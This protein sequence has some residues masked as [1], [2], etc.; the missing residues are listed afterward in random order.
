MF[1][2]RVGMACVSVGSDHALVTLPRAS[3]FVPS[4]SVNIQYRLCLFVALLPEHLKHKLGD[5]GEEG[6]YLDVCPDASTRTP[7]ILMLHR[8]VMCQVGT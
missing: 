2:V 1:L 7:R 6:F 5:R 4:R 3:S 8:G